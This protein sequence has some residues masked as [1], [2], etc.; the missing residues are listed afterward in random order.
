MRQGMFDPAST[1][2]ASLLFYERLE[3]SPVE[4]KDGVAPQSARDPEQY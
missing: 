1:Q 4:V 2:R 3:T